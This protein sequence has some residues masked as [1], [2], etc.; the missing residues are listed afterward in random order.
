MSLK[1]FEF[2]D[3][4]NNLFKKYYS[5]VNNFFLDKLKEFPS[6]GLQRQIMIF[7]LGLVRFYNIVKSY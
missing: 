1:T 7:Y 2:L 6:F 5:E 4:Q 3:L